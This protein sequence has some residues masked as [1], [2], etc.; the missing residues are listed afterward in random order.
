[1]II[2]KQILDTHDICG[3]GYDYCRNVIG[4][5][6]D[7]FVIDFNESILQIRNDPELSTEKRN[8][9]LY[10][11]LSLKD[12]IR[13]YQ[14]QSIGGF[15]EK[16]HVFNPITGQHENADSV[17]E[18]KTL[19]KKIIDAFVAHHKSTF[20]IQQEFFIESENRSLWQ[21]LPNQ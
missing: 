5:K 12:S 19:Q 21:V 11:T 16:Y 9:Y 14:A 3:D 13:F 15:V 17:E 6:T 7:N 2:N 4:D 10:Y 1:M 18:A 8:E 20:A